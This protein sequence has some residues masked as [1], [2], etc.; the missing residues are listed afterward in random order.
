MPGLAGE[1]QRRRALFDL[2]QERLD[3]AKLLVAPD[4][5]RGHRN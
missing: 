5:V 3:R 2:G 4:D 1:N